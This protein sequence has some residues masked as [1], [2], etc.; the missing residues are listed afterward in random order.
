M[1]TKGINKGNDEDLTVAFS[2]GAGGA[3]DGQSAETRLITAETNYL[4][5]PA[6]ETNYLRLPITG[7]TTKNITTFESEILNDKNIQD[8]RDIAQQ[9][10]ATI[11][12]ETD[13]DYKGAWD[14]ELGFAENNLWLFQIR[15]FVENKKAKSSDYLTSITPNIDYSKKVWVK[16]KLNYE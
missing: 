2:R 4:L 11:S 13:P 14:V 12:Q 1:I 8:I 10:R 6:R 16:K 7:G 15:P 9:I 3:V 5:A